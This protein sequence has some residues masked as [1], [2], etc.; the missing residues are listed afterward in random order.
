MRIRITGIPDTVLCLV[1][2]GVHSINPVLNG[3]PTC[4][5]HGVQHTVVSDWRGLLRYIR[6]SDSSD[7]SEVTH[8]GKGARRTLMFRAGINI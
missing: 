4:H 7:S 2:R 8:F 6:P 3:N 1:T 5:L